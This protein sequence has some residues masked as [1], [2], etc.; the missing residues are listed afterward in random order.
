MIQKLA[1]TKPPSKEALGAKPGD[2]EMRSGFT[3]PHTAELSTRDHLAEHPG[4]G[5]YRKKTSPHE[6]SKQQ[7]RP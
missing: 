7:K 1:A 6:G 2:L 4:P 3:S 5:P